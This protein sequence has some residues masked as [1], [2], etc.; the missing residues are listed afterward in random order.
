[1]NLFLDAFPE[2]DE[3]ETRHGRTFSAVLHSVT[4]PL[5]HLRTFIVWEDGLEQGRL[6]NLLEISPPPERSAVH[7]TT[8][9]LQVGGSVDVVWDGT[10]GRPKRADDVGGDFA[11]FMVEV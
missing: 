3:L 9:D 8:T 5:D 7:A 11:G 4:K 2:L 1:M 6:F 10:F